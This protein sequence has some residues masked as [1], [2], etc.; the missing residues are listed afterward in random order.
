MKLR[1][2]LSIAAVAVLVVLAGCAQQQVPQAA[3]TVT[4]TA[5][6][7][8]VTV[9]TTATPEQEATRLRYDSAKD[10]RDALVDGGLQ[11]D[12]WEDE[13]AN[14]SGMCGDVLIFTIEGDSVEHRN[15]LQAALFLTWSS[16]RDTDGTKVGLF[17][18]ENGFARV[19]VDDAY[20]LQET[21]GGG[22]VLGPKQDD[23]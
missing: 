3:P 23:D 17:V 21:L 6:T 10:F 16:I 5:P 20:T 13:T 8:T 7:P 2:V 4:V 14:L 15:V 9:T 12:D 22:V 11:C 18:T 19:N 1:S